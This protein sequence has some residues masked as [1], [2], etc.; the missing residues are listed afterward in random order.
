MEKVKLRE[1]YTVLFERQH[2]VPLATRS[3]TSTALQS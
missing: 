3:L 2:L 1:K